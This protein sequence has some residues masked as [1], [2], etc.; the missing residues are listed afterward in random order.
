[1]K[2][3][4][5][6]EVEREVVNLGGSVVVMEGTDAT[7]EESPTLDNVIIKLEDKAAIQ[8]VVVNRYTD[9]PGTMEPNIEDQDK[10]LIPQI[11]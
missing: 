4:I 3:A 2:E 1:M 6:K 9:T 8:K 10:A 11:R 7:A 5:I